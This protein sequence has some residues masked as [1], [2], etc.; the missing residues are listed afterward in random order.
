MIKGVTLLLLFQLLGE[1][2]VFVSGLALPGPVIGLVF[3][4]V[5]M[6]FCKAFRLDLLDEVEAAADGFLGNLG[7]LFVPAGVGI[8]ALWGEL[9][10]EAGA[11]L[12]VLVASTVLTLALTVWT[13]IIVRWFVGR[14]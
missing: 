9:Q 7:L 4:F 8:I 2:V 6:Q 10:S 13:F 5:A 3:L 12:A 11:I 1:S 14:G